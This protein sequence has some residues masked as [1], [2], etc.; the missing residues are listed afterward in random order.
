V[1]GPTISEVWNSFPRHSYLEDIIPVIKYKPS[2]LRL[3]G[4]SNDDQ[5]ASLRAHF[6]GLG[7]ASESI[8]ALET[9]KKADRIDY[10]VILL[11]ILT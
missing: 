11:P 3:S 1:S 8:K 9:L 10:N 4:K 6:E 2:G 5:I 7:L